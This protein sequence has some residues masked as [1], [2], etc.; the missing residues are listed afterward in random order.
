VQH[1][2]QQVEA[3]IRPQDALFIGVDGGGTKCKARLENAE[4][5]CLAEAVTGPANPATDLTQALESILQACQLVLQRAGFSSAELCRCYVV[6]GLAGVNVPEVQQQMQNW[7]HPFAALKVTTDLHIACVGAH[8]GKDGAILI[9]GTGTAAFASVAH[10]QFLFSAQ[11]FPLGDKSSGAWLGWQAV[12]ATLDSLDGLIEP[13]QLTQSLSRTLAVSSN[14][15]LISCCLHYR[16]GDYA[17]LA[18][19]VRSCYQQ[20]DLL[21]QRIIGQALV[22]IQALIQRLLQTGAGCIAMLGGLASFYAE[23]LPVD[24]QQ[25][26]SPVLGSPEAGAIALARAFYREKT[27]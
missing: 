16:A 3:I 23:L 17:R 26:L 25:Q 7:C 2:S 18:P 15:E 8:G 12:S 14:T 24:L 9:T 20:G 19:L 5:D 27:A 1:S 13:T 21:A 4:G 10:Q 22:Y 11:G 6:L